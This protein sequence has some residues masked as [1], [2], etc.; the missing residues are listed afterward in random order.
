MS[1]N[2]IMFTL[3]PTQMG[4]TNFNGYSIL[5]LRIFGYNVTHGSLCILSSLAKIPFESRV[6]MTNRRYWG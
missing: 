1:H 5:I 3:E 6:K 4:K 2:D